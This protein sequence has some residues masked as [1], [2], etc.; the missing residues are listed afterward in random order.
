MRDERHGA[1]IVDLREARHEGVAEFLDRRKEPQPQIVLRHAGEERPVERLVLRPHRP[2]QHLGAV[3]QRDVPLPFL[4]IGPDRKA[5]MAG[6][7]APRGFQRR[8]RDAGI[9]RDHAGLVGEQ[10]I[11]IEFAHL[12]QIGGELR[13]LDQHQRDRVG[14]GG[15]ARCDRP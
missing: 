15:R 14:I 3:A 13:E 7:P 10:R 6:R 8:D 12:R 4:R 2:H 11:E 9:D 1:R 5:R